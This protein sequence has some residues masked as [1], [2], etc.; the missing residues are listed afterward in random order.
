MKRTTLILTAAAV[1]A[2]GAAGC[3]SPAGGANAGASPTPT[4]S[5]DEFATLKEFAK[6]VR[7]NGMP[8]FPDPVRQADGRISFPVPEGRGKLPSNRA[9][10]AC[11]SILRKIPGMKGETVPPAELAKMREFSKCMRDNGLRDWPDPT[12]EGAFPLPKRLYDLGKRGF[13]DQLKKCRGILP[14]KGLHVTEG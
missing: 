13:V 11:K 12:T 2:A 7:A 10:E 8:G 3:A 6:C 1:L 14:G 4:A 5:V 9:T